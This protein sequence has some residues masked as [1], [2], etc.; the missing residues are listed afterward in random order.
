MKIIESLKP[1]LVDIDSVK[2]DPHNARQRGTPKLV[3][4]IDCGETRFVRADTNPVRCLRCA[5]L[6]GAH[7][8]RSKR[9]GRYITCAYCGKMTWS[10]PSE[11]RHY[12]SKECADNGRA[13]RPRELRIC[14][15]CS[16]QFQWRPTQ[17]NRRGTYCSVQCRN[18]DYQNF[19]R[20]RRIAH[21]LE[22]R[23]G[24]SRMRR[25]HIKA[26]D[27]CV[28]CGSHKGLSVHHVIPYRQ[29]LDHS[30]INLITLCHKHHVAMQRL[31]DM[32]LTY[33]PRVQEIFRYLLQ[34]ECQDRWL[35]FKGRELEQQAQWN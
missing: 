28:I 23:E 33:S 20:G 7:A 14:L 6:K 30:N 15:T 3:V 12:C 9:T 27:F 18:K 17:S 4:C 5:S 24:W 32:V 26:N 11:N 31:S 1:L 25:Q 10:T 35:I 22:K 8:Q 19:Y 13:N 16:K 2:Q 29:S 21:H 34:A